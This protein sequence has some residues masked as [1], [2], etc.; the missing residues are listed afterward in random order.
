MPEIKS[1]PELLRSIRKKSF[2]NVY[3]LHGEEAFYI[4]ALT[5]ALQEN[6]LTEDEK[7]FNETIVYGKDVD[8][9]YI[10]DCLRRYPTFAAYQVVIVKE[11][12]DLKQMELLEKYLEHPVESSILVL[13]HKHKSLDKRKKW[14]KG[15]EKSDKIVIFESKKLYDN[16]VGAWIRDYL[17]DKQYKVDAKALELLTQYLGNDLAKIANELDKL[18]INIPPSVTILS[19]HI[20]ENIGISKDYNVFELQAALAQKN[21]LKTFEII[22]NFINNPKEQPLPMVFGA[23]YNF[24]SKVY[25]LNFHRQES[26]SELAKIIG[27]SPFMLKEYKAALQHYKKT[28]LEEVLHLIK[29]YDLRSKGIALDYKDDLLFSESTPYEGL[30]T[31]FVYHVLNS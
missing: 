27:V 19:Q 7:S 13:A 22:R 26:D 31:E 30:L 3:I 15:I 25:Q 2:H 12:Q 18:M 16:Q 28:N 5:E 1:Y 24:F 14:I 8:V 6:V 23:L 10:I 20:Q 21:T 11:A 29:N 4:D 17:T 9:K